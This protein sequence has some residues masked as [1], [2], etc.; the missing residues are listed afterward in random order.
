M[1]QTEDQYAAECAEWRRRAEQAEA[2]VARLEACYR[3]LKND[4]RIGQHMSNCGCGTCV[5]I[6]AVEAARRA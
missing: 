6:A 2:L 1:S 3:R 5:D 4:A